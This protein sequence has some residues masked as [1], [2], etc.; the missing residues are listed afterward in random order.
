M[1]SVGY[2]SAS[3]ATAAAAATL[4]EPDDQPG[5]VNTPSIVGEAPLWQVVDRDK[6]AQRWTAAPSQKE[7]VQNL[8][9]V[10]IHSMRC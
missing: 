5:D 8:S 1:S 10:V 2:V 4:R 6:E 9:D 3:P 7:Q